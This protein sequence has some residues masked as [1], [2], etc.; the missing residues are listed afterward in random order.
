MDLNN[1][2]RVAKQQIKRVLRELAMMQD[3]KGSLMLEWW[4]SNL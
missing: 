1:R 2:M 3:T 4:L